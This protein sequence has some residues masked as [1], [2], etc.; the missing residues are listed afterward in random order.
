MLCCEFMFRGFLE[1]ESGTCRS[2]PGSSSFSRLLVPLTQL[3]FR[4]KTSAGQL[5]S[6]CRHQ[7]VQCLSFRGSTGELGLNVPR[8]RSRAKRIMR[9]ES[10]SCRLLHT[11]FPSHFEWHD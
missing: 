6:N 3:V 10:G 11:V 4:F 9:P 1:D 7:P 2:S 5:I 8:S